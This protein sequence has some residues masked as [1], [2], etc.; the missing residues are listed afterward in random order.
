[1]FTKD[2]LRYDKVNGSYERRIISTVASRIGDVA[3]THLSS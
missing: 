3:T 1:M 2:I